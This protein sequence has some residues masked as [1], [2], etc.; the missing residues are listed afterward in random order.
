MLPELGTMKVRARSQ[1]RIE[2]GMGRAPAVVGWPLIVGGLWL[3]VVV[4]PIAAW[5]AVAAL[6]VAALGWTMVTA[7]HHLVFD[8]DDGVLRIDRGVLGLGARAVV[9]LF[10]L[11]AVAVRC[12][13]AGFVATIER[14]NGE[15]IVIDTCDRAGP[16]Y[17][18]A[19]AVADVTDLRLVYDATRA[20]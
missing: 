6:A 18:L 7:R 17:E 11:R 1:S 20:S 3:A 2:L 19:R 15:P 13:G 4:A 8:T 12:R 16:L 14:R 5:L 9:P 10:H